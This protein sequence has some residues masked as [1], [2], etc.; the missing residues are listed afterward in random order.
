MAGGNKEIA[1]RIRLELSFLQ[2]QY[3]SLRVG[4][5]IDNAITMYY[6]HVEQKPPRALFYIE[7]E[8]MLKALQCYKS[9]ANALSS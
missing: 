3:P 9:L 5:L 1:H 8:E 2:E 4:Q 7:D 6:R